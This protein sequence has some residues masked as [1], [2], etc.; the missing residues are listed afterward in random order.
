MNKFG[1]TDEV[2]DSQIVETK[3]EIDK[4]CECCAGDMDF[5]PSTGGLLCPF[6]GHK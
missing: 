4:K 2:L 3:Q 1:L 6:C 5:D